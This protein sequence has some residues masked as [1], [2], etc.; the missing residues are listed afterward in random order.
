MAYL[1]KNPHVDPK[2]FRRDSTKRMLG[3]LRNEMENIEQKIAW[4]RNKIR[5]LQA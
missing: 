1:A 2:G 5:E 4:H 3:H